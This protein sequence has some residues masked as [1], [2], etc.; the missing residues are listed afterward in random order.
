MRERRSWGFLPLG[1]LN[2]PSSRLCSTPAQRTLLSHL[3]LTCVCVWGGVCGLLPS[4]L[5]LGSG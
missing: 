2:P 1:A 5:S 4:S 3:H